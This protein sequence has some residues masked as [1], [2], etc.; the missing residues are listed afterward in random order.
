MEKNDKE[1]NEGQVPEVVKEE[2]DDKPAGKGIM[3]AIV[4]AVVILAIIYFVF[5]KNDVGFDS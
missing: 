4:I 5:F 2:A 1:E 3:W